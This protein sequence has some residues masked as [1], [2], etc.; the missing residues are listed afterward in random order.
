MLELRIVKG[1]A[2]M[3]QTY[4]LNLGQSLVLG[5]G[6]DCDVMLASKGIS[7]RHCRVTAVAG[8][9]LEVEDLK[10]SNGTFINGVLVKKHF[11]KPGDSLNL[12]DFTLQVF[13]RAPDHFAGHHATSG[14]V[15][16]EAVADGRTPTTPKDEGPAVT[17]WL[18]ANVY[19]W[20]DRL[21]QNIDVRSLLAGFFVLWS[22]LIIVVTASPFS[23]KANLRVEEQAVEVARL[24]ARQLVR[25]NQ[26][27]IV[28]Q[29]YRNLISELDERP[30]RTNGLVQA[31]IL[32]TQ[33]AQI[34]APS[35]LFGQS[36]PNHFAATAIN[37]DTEYFAVDDDG[38]AYASAPIRVGTPSGNKTMATAFVIFDTGKNKFTIASLVDQ[39]VTSLLIS[40]ATSLLFILF[41]YRWIDG[42]VDQLSTRVDNAL[43]NA[44]PNVQ[45]SVKWPALQALTEQ[46]SFALGRAQGGGAGNSAAGGAGEWARA[47]VNGSRT[48]AAALTADL[49][50]N[51]WNSAMENLI[52]I[53]AN[54]AIGS[55]ISG[56]SRDVS[57]EAAIRDLTA[58]APL[59]PWS[60]LS[61]EL[62]FSG[63]RYLLSVVYG[64][65]AHLAQIS[66]IED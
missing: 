42:S 29:R 40:L 4:N 41:I 23:Q 31:L 52:G 17:R 56:A 65:G 44:E 43:K 33:N 27:A 62:E 53:R 46:I 59:S 54:L 13:V 3:G 66:R 63:N 48:A 2:Q 12:H 51:A 20:A 15:N 11:L 47:V 22:V 24:Y 1:P 7:K 49:I 18:N 57:F 55:D 58:Q 36:L 16:I 28:D 37:K 10:S 9:R 60:P 45:I 35:D 25:I 21:S 30:G 6:E 5:R 64:D 8:S 26:Q 61:R 32:N 14:H 34:L 39:I 38:I 50:V 19:P